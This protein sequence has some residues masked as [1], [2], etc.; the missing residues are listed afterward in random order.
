MIFNQKKTPI[1]LLV[2]N[3]TGDRIQFGLAQEKARLEGYRVRT[4][5]IEDDC[6]SYGTSDKPADQPNQK[7]KV[8]QRGVAGVYLVYRMANA[9]AQLCPEDQGLDWLCDQLQLA[10]RMISTYSVVLEPGA[11]PG[12]G[13][14]F[15]LPADRVEFGSGVHGELGVKR[16]E[17]S[18]VNSLIDQLLQQLLHSAAK[19]LNQL[20]VTHPQYEESL[21]SLCSS[22]QPLPVAVLVNNLGGCSQFEINCIC[23]EVL[24]QMNQSVDNQIE[25]GDSRRI[26]LKVLWIRSGCFMT[27]FDAH[28]VSVSVF[29]LADR[30]WLDWLQSSEKTAAAVGA[31]LGGSLN[32]DP[33]R[34]EPVGEESK[35]KYEDELIEFEDD[36]LAA[37]RAGCQQ[38]IANEQLLNQLDAG[39]G[40][41]DC[42]STMAKMGRLLLQRLQQNRIKASFEQIA[43]EIGTGGVG[44]TSGAIYSLL[45]AGASAAVLEW[46]K[47]KGKVEYEQRNQFWALLVENAIR[48]V[49]E[50]GRADLGDRTMLDA[51]WSLPKEL[52]TNDIDCEEKRS[53]LV[54][55]IR[56]AAEQTAALEAKAGEREHEI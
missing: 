4:L 43:E 17:L 42:G 28:G 33:I 31:E 7:S 22:L 10:S 27:S 37:L 23:N 34:A 38:M 24:L 12:V 1:L 18:P 2:L 6:V 9:L 56:Q 41:C 8:G 53:Q 11:I 21:T 3:Y 45:C 44:G 51:L 48:T 26:L 29:P 54:S 16:V 36:F 40:D 19:K 15:E 49:R 32:E 25:L 30:E 47:S 52:R 46:R 14:T 13:H 55:K 20:I 39:T 35:S 5:V 50:Y